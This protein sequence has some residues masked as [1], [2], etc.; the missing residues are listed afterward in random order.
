MLFIGMPIVAA[1]CGATLVAA[2]ATSM[3]PLAVIQR[4]F[5][6]IDSFTLLAVPFFMFSGAVMERGGVSRK[7]I[8]LFSLYLEGLPGGLAIVTIVAC[9]FFGA[10][11]GSAPA[12][13]AAI[14]GIMLPAMLKAGY[15]KGFALATIATAGCLGSIIPPSIMMVSY[16]VSTNSSIGNLFLIGIFPGLLLCLAFSAFSFFFGVKHEYY[17]KKDA[18]NS[19]PFREQLKV[20]WSSIPAILIPVIILGGIY[21]GFFT[22][23]EA[24][25]VAA[26]YGLLV[27]FFVYREL[28]VS[29]LPDIAVETM[30]NTS[31]IMLIV[32]GAGAFGSLMTKF[33]VPATVAAYITSM[34]TSPFVF[35]LLVN[36]MLLVVGTF[37][38]ANA[39]IILIA[40]LLAPIAQS[41]GIDLLFFGIIM[42]VNL[43]FGL[44]TPPVG[45]NLFVACGIIG[46][47][48]KDILTRHL[49]YYVAICMIMLMI[50]TYFPSVTMLL[51]NLVKS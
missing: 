14:G 50:F 48:M 9:T 33:Q 10:I 45:I 17:T 1:L 29:Q 39:A 37:M 13:V 41:Y 35:L 8:N 31:M 25:N 23:T 51:F 18:R 28:K 7:L 30:I 16:G 44:L 6:N 2:F 15:E 38:E 36:L 26:V 34:T 12:T 47:K 43:V 11:S 21:G 42:V 20:I 5:G 19:V 3:S 27:G 4:F 40:P 22:P 32:A 46:C 24:G 49:C